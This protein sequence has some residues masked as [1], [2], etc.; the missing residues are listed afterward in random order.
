MRPVPPPAHRDHPDGPGA[1]S[2]A[3]ARGGHHGGARS[4]TLTHP[5]LHHAPRRAPSGNQNG[6]RWRRQPH[7]HRPR[8]HSPAPVLPLPTPEDASTPGAGPTPLPEPPSRGPTRRRGPL[9][10]DPGP[11][12]C[13]SAGGGRALTEAAGGRRVAGCGLVRGGARHAPLGGR[14]LGRRRGAQG[15][16]A[17]AAV[18]GRWLASH[19]ARQFTCPRRLNGAWRAG[20]LWRRVSSAARRAPAPRSRPAAPAAPV[21]SRASTA[22]YQWER[23]AAGQQARGGGRGG[24]ERRGGEGRVRA[25]VPRAGGYSP[26]LRFGSA[27]CCHF[28]ANPSLRRDRILWSS[29]SRNLAGPG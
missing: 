10:G 17:A 19:P 29:D 8:A 9:Q 14:L 24:A 27:S 4:S 5:V 16:G 26:R 18:S 11:S 22:G 23:G 20:G 12:S 1:G 21:Q 15:A 13:P 28:S 2:L 3:G 25:G 7:G 6:L